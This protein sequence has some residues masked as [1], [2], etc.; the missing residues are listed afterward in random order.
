V[1][2]RELVP[3]VAVDNAQVGTGRPGPVTLALLEAYREFVRRSS[4]D[5]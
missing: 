5:G 4:S 3:V 2:T 1:T